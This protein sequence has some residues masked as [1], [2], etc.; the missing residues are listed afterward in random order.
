MKKGLPDTLLLWRVGDFYEA[1]DADAAA[2]AEALDSVLATIGGMTPMSGFPHT[3]LLSRVD[4]LVALGFKVAVVEPE[5]SQSLQVY[6]KQQ[7]PAPAVEPV[8]FDGELVATQP[9]LFQGW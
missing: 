7:E 4:R 1:L 3:K 9:A 6:G 2:L 5:G 8:V